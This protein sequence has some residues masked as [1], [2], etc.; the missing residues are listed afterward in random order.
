MADGLLKIIRLN[1]IDSD[2]A[3]TD[4][5]KLQQDGR[6]VWP[7]SDGAYFSVSVG[8]SVVLNKTLPFRDQT[9]ITL[10]DAE[11]IG[12]DDNLGSLYFHVHDTGNEEQTAEIRGRGSLYTMNYKI[13]DVSGF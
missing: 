8:N 1:C 10:Y 13:K 9:T 11:D 12:A 3:V 4:E 7:E 6:Q 2:D 5:L